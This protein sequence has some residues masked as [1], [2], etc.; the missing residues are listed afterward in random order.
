M[1]LLAVYRFGEMAAVYQRMGQS[2]NEE[3]KG[4][5]SRQT[6]VELWLLQDC[7]LAQLMEPKF[8]ADAVNFMVLE[9]C[10]WHLP[11]PYI[12]TCGPTIHAAAAY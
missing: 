5:A 6:P 10:R 4:P 1:H 2:P 7:C 12:S 8:A 9:V 11:C 3:Q